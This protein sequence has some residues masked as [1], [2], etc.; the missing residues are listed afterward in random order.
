VD[1]GVADRADRDDHHVEGV[2]DVPAVD[3][4]VAGDADHDHDGEQGEGETKAEQ[5]MLRSHDPSA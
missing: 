3:E 4:H 1:L 5:R 2:E